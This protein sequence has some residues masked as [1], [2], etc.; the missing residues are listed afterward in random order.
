MRKIS[1]GIVLLVI[2]CFSLNLSVVAATNINQIINQMK[3]SYQKQLSGM[4]DLMITQEMEGDFVSM[5]STIFQKKAT[6]NGQVVLKSRSEN[7]VMGITMVTIFDGVY[8]W[9]IDPISGEV[10]KE[11][12]E[13]DPLQIWK[14]FDPEKMQYFGE[15]KIDNKAAY[16]VQLNDNIWMMGK[17]DLSSSGMPEDSEVD[18]YSIFWIDKS[19]YIP[20]RA[21]NVL[22]TTTIEDGREINMLNITDVKFLDYRQVGTM[23]ISHKMIIS[24][25]M[26][27]NDPTMSAEE[28][29]QAQAFMN[30]MGEMEF[31]VKE[32]KMNSGLSD[33]LFDG[34]TLEPQEP[35]FKQ[36][37]GMSQNESDSNEM[38]SFSE[39]DVKKMMESV[40]E[41]N[42]GLE[43]MMQNMLNN[44]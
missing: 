19:D 10:Q 36:M 29:E 3:Q 8:T 26:E 35:M 38:Q 27:I 33:S 20:L 21:K 44:N 13:F 43:D 17:E 1:F 15:E 30:T 7:N 40:M 37:P 6:I 16:K 22:D 32:V 14:V 42:E 39:E 4:S 11:K 31:V 25:Q 24:S 18:M 41:G 23:L 12:S 9:S 28:K 2:I 5:E 34:T